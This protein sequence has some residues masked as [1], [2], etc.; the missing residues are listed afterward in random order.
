M[1]RKSGNRKVRASY[2]TSAVTPFY[3]GESQEK[4]LLPRLEGAEMFA[5]SP[6]YVMLGG[7]W[8]FWFLVDSFCGR[9]GAFG[10]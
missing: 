4:K 5:V 2:R 6:A 7:F 9:D 3:K 8:G 10:F 1:P